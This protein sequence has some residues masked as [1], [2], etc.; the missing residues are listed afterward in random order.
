MDLAQR[1]ASI[2]IITADIDP[3]KYA[4]DLKEM[5]KLQA[6]ALNKQYAANT[7]ILQ[8]QQAQWKTY[9]DEVGNGFQSAVNQWIKTGQGFNASMQNV[10]AELVTMFADH[11]LQIG[12]KWLE[13]K[14]QNLAVTIATNTEEE[15]S[16]TQ[17]AVQGAATAQAANAV[18]Q[19]AAAKV[20][21]ANTYAVVSGWPVV[22]PILAPPAAAGAFAAVLAF[23]GGGIVPNVVTPAILHP[24]EMV[25]PAHI[26]TF[27]QGAAADA[28]GPSGGNTANI[29]TVNNYSGLTDA[30]WK[31]MATK[32]AS[33]LTA[34]VVKGLRQSN[35]I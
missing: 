12:I 3:T 31:A 34:T 1:L 20:A 26:S 23:E 15:T 29:S 24:Q 18:S 19:F 9:F 35:I 2:H 13:L 16:D 32:H 28:T 10:G 25:L 6:D 5:A 27:I 22:G 4:T 21:A 14:A 7:K 17:V 8:L 30:A 11:F 33:H